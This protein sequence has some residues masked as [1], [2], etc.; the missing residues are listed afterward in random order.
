MADDLPP[1]QATRSGMIDIIIDLIQNASEALTEGGTIAVSAEQTQSSVRLSVK[2]NGVGMDAETLR[3]AADPFFTTKN[4]V[5]SGTT[6][7][8]D[9]VATDG[10]D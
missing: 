3:R 8:V 5:G 10:S 6:A 2:D 1:V 7:L 4:D 9:L